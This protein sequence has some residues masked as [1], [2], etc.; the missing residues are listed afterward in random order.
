MTPSE[1]YA[2]RLDAVDAQNARFYGP[3]TG[4]DVWAGPAARQFRFDPHRA[5][6]RNLALIASYVRPDDVFVDV[7]GGAGRVCLP[8]SLNCREVVNGEPSPGMAAEFEWLAG[9]A[10][11]DNARRVPSLLSED[12]WE[13]GDSHLNATVT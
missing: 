12:G 10:G 13:Q 3:A 11:I 4:G 6:D 1:I 9:E 7:G 2:G 8:L 5:P